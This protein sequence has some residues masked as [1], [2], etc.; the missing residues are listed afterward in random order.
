MWTLASTCNESCLPRRRASPSSMAVFGRAIKALTC[1]FGAP[2]GTRTPN[3]RIKRAT[4]VYPCWSR[5]VPAGPV[6]SGSFGFVV[7]LHADWSAPCVAGSW[8]P[9]TPRAH[10]SSTM[11]R[12]ALVTEGCTTCWGFSANVRVQ[13]GATGTRSG[14]PAAVPASAVTLLLVVDAGHVAFGCEFGNRAVAATGGGT[15]IV[16]PHGRGYFGRPPPRLAMTSTTIVPG[17]YTWPGSA[18]RSEPARTA[19]APRLP[20]RAPTPDSACLA[21]RLGAVEHGPGPSRRR[22]GDYLHCDGAITHARVVAGQRSRRT[23]TARGIPSTCIL[24]PSTLTSGR[25]LYW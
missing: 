12:T 24:L 8:R 17:R 5:G 21:C 23:R 14:D 15:W 20:S 6:W 11:D 2:P 1:S 10:G 13:P 3:P 7:E 9:S 4:I 25:Y 22:V 19:A 16:G 18:I